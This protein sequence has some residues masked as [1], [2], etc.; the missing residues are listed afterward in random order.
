MFSIYTT[1]SPS[2]HIIRKGRCRLKKHLQVWFNNLLAPMS[3]ADTYM[4]RH[5]C[6][7]NFIFA[8]VRLT[9]PELNVRKPCKLE[10]DCLASATMPRWNL[11]L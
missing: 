7:R 1:N 4:M 5:T 9:E 2:A 8:L 3:I 10:D 11:W 6:C